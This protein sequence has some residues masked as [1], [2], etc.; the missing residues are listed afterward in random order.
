MELT[1]DGSTPFLTMKYRLTTLSRITSIY[2]FHIA[3]PFVPAR[4]QR[5]DLEGKSGVSD[6]GK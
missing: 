2:P 6:P 1:W 4:S 3:N 5:M